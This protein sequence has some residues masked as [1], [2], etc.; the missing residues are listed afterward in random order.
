M[1]STGK[2]AL[3]VDL[4]G[5]RI[6]QGDVH[7]SLQT[8]LDDVRDNIRLGLVGVSADA[9]H[10]GTL[11]DVLLAG[12]G[13]SLSTQNSAGDETLTIDADIDGIDLDATAGESLSIRDM[14]YLNEAN[15][16]WYKQDSNATGSVAMGRVRGCATEAISADATGKVRILGEVSGFSSLTAWSKVYASTTAGSY[17]QTKPFASSAGTQIILSEMGYAISST[18]MW[19]EPQE[20][21]YRKRGTVANGGTLS[22]EHHADTETYERDIDVQAISIIVGSSLTSHSNH[23][24]HYPLNGADANGFDGAII[25]AATPQSQT[26]NVGNVSG[27]SN[28]LAH[29]F[30]G[31]GYITELTISFLS[32]TGSPVGTLTWEIQTDSSGEP[33]GT[34]LQSGTFTPTASATSTITIVDGVLVDDGWLVLYST[35]PQASGKYWRI[36]KALSG[37][38]VFGE[39]TDGGS[40][41][42]IYGS[43]TLGI[44]WTY[45]GGDPSSR[46]AQSFQIGSTTTVGTIALYL[47]KFGTPTG[48]LT[49]SIQTNSGSS[50][51][52]TVISNGTADTVSA[53]DVASSFGWISFTFSVPTSLTTATTYW[54]VL[55]TTDSQSD[56]DFVTWAIEFVAESYASGQ[57]KMYDGSWHTDVTA[58]AIFNVYEEGEIYHSQTLL[59]DWNSALA[60][61]L[62]RLDDGAGANDTT[63][64]TIK[65]N[66]GSEAI[67]ELAI[68]FERGEA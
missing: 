47:A 67:L 37:A 9:T 30:N 33:S 46:L 12:D 22:L 65:N 60:T 19:I 20:L 44:G 56:T 59:D 1:T 53:S 8:A 43:D 31:T 41:W 48:D 3:T 50:P 18:V 63:Q 62:A 32:S 42:T 16:K 52:G 40:S 10:I 17:T 61:I 6:R 28:R 25:P 58:D 2:T 29:K 7:G 45:I 13:I 39:S 49:L 66:T 14:V 51:S 26:A 36:G 35:T 54:M 57:M 68:T 21:S 5:I 23:E 15:G 24:S 34:V 4:S 11:E 55:E 64:T 27:T 38:F